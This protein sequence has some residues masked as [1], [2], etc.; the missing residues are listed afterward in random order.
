MYPQTLSVCLYIYLEIG[1]ERVREPHVAWK[2][3]EDEVAELDAVGWDN[4]TEAIVVVTQELW[5]VMQQDQQHPQCTLKQ[6]S[7]LVLGCYPNI[8][9]Q[10]L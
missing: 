5:E 3:T 9:Y 2:G 4:V 8:F 1:C 6:R 10:A 7:V